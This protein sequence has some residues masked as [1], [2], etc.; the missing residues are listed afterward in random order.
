[1]SDLKPSVAKL[2]SIDH[3]S[4]TPPGKRI[5]SKDFYIIKFE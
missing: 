2:P 4:F 3:V 1:M 5:L